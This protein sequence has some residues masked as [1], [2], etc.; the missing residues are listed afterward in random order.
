MFHEIVHKPLQNQNFSS[1]LAPYNRCESHSQ[2]LWQRTEVQ[3]NAAPA[4]LIDDLDWV[5]IAALSN[6][7]VYSEGETQ[8]WVELR[9]RCRLLHETICGVGGDHVI[10][11]LCQYAYEYWWRQPWCLHQQQS[12]IEAGVVQIRHPGVAL[13]C[14][15]WIAPE[16]CSI[17]VILQR[18]SLI[19]PRISRITIR[20][21]IQHR[22]CEQLIRFVV[23]GRVVEL[24]KLQAWLSHHVSVR[25]NTNSIFPI[26]IIYKYSC[27]VKSWISWCLGQT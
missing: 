23:W 17:T 22:S 7:I 5:A 9:G 2:E 14:H 8:S 26:L 12:C 24:S 20:D 19:T 1:V 10:D 21:E 16:C 25:C 4:V 6:N 15:P 18:V 3:I 27:I 11:E 13:C